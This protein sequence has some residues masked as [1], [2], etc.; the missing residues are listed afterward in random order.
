MAY[1][2]FFLRAINKPPYMLT[3]ILRTPT[4]TKMAGAARKRDGI[5]V[6]KLRNEAMAAPPNP[7]ITVPIAWEC[8]CVGGGGEIVFECVILQCIHNFLW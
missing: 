1:N 5:T 8:V 4:A 2:G 7:T 3:K 6:G